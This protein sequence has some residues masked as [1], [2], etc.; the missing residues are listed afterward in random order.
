MSA[1]STSRAY[2]TFTL[3]TLDMN[4]EA[5][6]VDD[7]ETQHTVQI[8]AMSL[9]ELCRAVGSFSADTIVFH[10]QVY[11]EGDITHN[12]VSLFC[13]SGSQ[14]YECTHYHQARIHDGQT[15]IVCDEDGEHRHVEDYD[16][17]RKK[18]KTVFRGRYMASHLSNFLKSIDKGRV[19]LSFSTNDGMAGAMIAKFKLGTHESFMSLLLPPL[20]DNDDDDDDQE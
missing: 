14:S 9:K 6:E 8:A 1:G 10:L 7:V 12:F 17:Y 19:E 20:D 4:S 5:G 18:A 13:D 11:S 15:T 3:K 16:V 2:Q